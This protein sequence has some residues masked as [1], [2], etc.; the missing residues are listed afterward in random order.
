MPARG[1]WKTTSGQV[2]CSSGTCVDACGGSLTLCGAACVDGTT[3]AARCGGCGNA[4]AQGECRT[5]AAC[6]CAA[7]TT[8]WCAQSVISPA[9]FNQQTPI[10]ALS[11]TDGALHTGKGID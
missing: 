11:V 9:T 5:G 10:G 2:G 8:T 6:A 7:G 4:C 3:D 1:Q